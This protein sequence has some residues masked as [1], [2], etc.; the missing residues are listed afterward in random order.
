MASVE[1]GVAIGPFL[2]L[3]P[4]VLTTIFLENVEHSFDSFTTILSISH[5]CSLWRMIALEF[6]DLWRCFAF[7]HQDGQGCHPPAVEFSKAILARCGNMTLDVGWE[8]NLQ[9]I[10]HR[11]PQEYLASIELEAMNMYRIQSY[12]GE[13]FDELVDKLGQI[14]QQQLN[15]PP[16][17]GALEDLTLVSTRYAPQIPACLFDLTTPRLRALTLRRYQVTRI[18]WLNLG[19][20]Q[21]L[22]VSVPS[23][24][25]PWTWK[26]WTSL[27]LQ[28]T[29]LRRLRLQMERDTPTL[30][31]DSDPIP[32][33]ALPFLE[34]VYL[35]VPLPSLPLYISHLPLSNVKILQLA[36]MCKFLYRESHPQTEDLLSA[37]QQLIEKVILPSIGAAKDHR[38]HID[39][40]DGAYL[41][42]TF[43]PS[44][45]TISMG[46]TG[47]LTRAEIRTR[48]SLQHYTTAMILKTSLNGFNSIVS[49]VKTLSARIPPPIAGNM[50]NLSLPMEDFLMSATSVTRLSN[51][52]PRMLG[53]LSYLE[54]GQAVS[55]S[56]SC[57]LPSLEGLVYSGRSG[58][59]VIFDEG[60]VEALR[61]FLRDWKRC[62]R[63][64]KYFEASKAFKS[65]IEYVL[66]EHGV[67]FRA[68]S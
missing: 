53:I 50:C 5:V 66:V 47:R 43:Y 55:T 44:A 56:N 40:V 16:P 31:T 34:N 17:M 62:G 28:C 21:E 59:M 8:R 35:D 67:E 42:V 7:L 6:P 51:P 12:T 14:R 3:P 9:C 63:S 57:I 68:T 25:S 46:G 27:L 19:N 33:G 58:E 61:T 30:P 45:T 18:E 54:K 10:W 2:R 48:V 39:V 23:R 26:K 37:C 65:G 32:T 49:L 13:L 60:Y 15:Q 20:L 4:E 38:L 22:D 29:R 36:S 11:S 41:S 64:I 52:P 1:D 24:H